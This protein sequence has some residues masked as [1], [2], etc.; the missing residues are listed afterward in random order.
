MSDPREYVESRDG[1]YY[2]PGSRVSL[3]SIIHN[4]LQGASPEAI[5][6]NFPTL[7]LAQVYGAI[8]FYLNHPEE[9]E[10]YLRKQKTRWEELERNAKPPSAEM[11]ARIERI[12]QQLF[13]GQP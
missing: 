2:I 12:R 8:A 4:F 1:G 13:A 7:S 9:C 3:D 5:R 6:E 11:L 10:A